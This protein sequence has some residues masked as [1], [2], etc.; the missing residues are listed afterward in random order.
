VVTPYH[1][2]CDNTE[3]STREPLYERLY[4]GGVTMVPDTTLTGIEADGDGRLRVRC[5]N[6]YSGRA[7]AIDAVDTVVLA[8]GGRAVDGLYRA[9][10]GRVPELYLVGDAMAPRLLHDALLEGTRAGRRV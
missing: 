1:T 8:Y 10:E 9:L 5:L 2:V 7:W 6:E 3:G 4:R